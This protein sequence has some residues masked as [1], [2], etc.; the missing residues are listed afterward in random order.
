M[1]FVQS[2]TK[3]TAPT[4]PAAP[5]TLNSVSNGESA[6]HCNQWLEVATGWTL[7][8]GTPFSCRR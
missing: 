7:F 6:N 1:K 5:D 8:C 3:C 4:Q 2:Q